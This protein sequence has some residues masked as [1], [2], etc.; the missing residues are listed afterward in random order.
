[1]GGRPS[2]TKQKKTIHSKARKETTKFNK[3]KLQSCKQP[4]FGETV[5]IVHQA[6]YIKNSYKSKYKLEDVWK[7]YLKR[8]CK[9]PVREWMLVAQSC[10]T[11]R[12]HGLQP[13]RLLCPWD[14]AGKDA[15]VGCHFFLQGIFLTQGS[16]PGFLHCRQILYRLT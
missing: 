3:S 1:M 14:F 13:T 4:N 6:E 8:K 16:N 5:C 2:K 10:L 7:A 11:L 12:P 15:G 9:W